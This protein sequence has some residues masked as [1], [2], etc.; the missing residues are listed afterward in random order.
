MVFIFA[1][2]GDL[3]VLWV[4]RNVDARAMVQDH[5][6]RAGCLVVGHGDE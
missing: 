1:A 2:G 4:I 5:P 3:L 6:S